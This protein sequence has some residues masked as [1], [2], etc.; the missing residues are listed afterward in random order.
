MK[1]TKLVPASVSLFE[2]LEKIKNH[3]WYAIYAVVNSVQVVK[4]ADEDEAR[5]LAD[6]RSGVIIHGEILDY[7][8]AKPKKEIKDEPAKPAPTLS[9]V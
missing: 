9:Q 2:S 8:K 1:T 4:C 3:S 7:I 6:S 5:K